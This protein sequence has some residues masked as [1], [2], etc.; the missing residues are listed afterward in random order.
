MSPGCQDHPQVCGFAGRTPRT[1][2]AVMIVAKIYY[3]QR[4]QSKMST[5]QR[6]TERSLEEARHELV[7]VGSQ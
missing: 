7:R 3:S 5:G 6:F 4:L 1:Q 2:Y